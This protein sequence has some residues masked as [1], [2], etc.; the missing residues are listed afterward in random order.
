MTTN[1]LPRRLAAAAGLAALI[2]LGGLTA[3]G[4]GGEK[5]PSTPTTTTTTTTTTT[6]PSS[7]PTVAPTEKS[8]NPGGGNLFT[9]THVVTPAPPTGG[10]KGGH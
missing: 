8:I 2:T 10:G 4:T 6:A 5:E 3:C 7:A 1:H 9:P